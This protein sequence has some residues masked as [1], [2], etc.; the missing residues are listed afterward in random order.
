[1]PRGAEPAPA[2]QDFP[3]NPVFEALPVDVRAALF[4]LVEI[5]LGLRETAFI[6]ETDPNH[7]AKL[8]AASTQA[9]AAG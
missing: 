8:L 2:S 6:L 4:L 7:L 5:E 9:L 3:R 1:M